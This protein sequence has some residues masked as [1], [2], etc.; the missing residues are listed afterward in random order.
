MRRWSMIVI[1]VAIVA[2]VL[3]YSGIAARDGN[4]VL[5]ST[6]VVGMQVVGIHGKYLGKINGLV[7]NPEG[8]IVAAL[9]DLG[10]FS[11]TGEKYIAVPGVA[12]RSSDNGTKIVL[13]TTFDEFSESARLAEDLMQPS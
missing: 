4:G 13:D 8:D 2:A 7:M 10:G 9:I 12:L 1:V 5:K 3:G 11:R 6:D